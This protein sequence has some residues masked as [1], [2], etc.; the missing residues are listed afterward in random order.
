MSVSIIEALQGAQHNLSNVKFLGTA[1]VP[2][3]ERQ[4]NNSITLLDK[5]YPLD[6]LIEPL[7]EKWGDVDNVPDFS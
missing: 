2:L 5:G 7:L 3:I 1:I 4:L 6:T